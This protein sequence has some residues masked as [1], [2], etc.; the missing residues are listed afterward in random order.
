[1]ADRVRPG[2]RAD[3]F[4]GIDERTIANRA[5]AYIYKLA[6]LIVAP[7]EEIPKAQTNAGRSIGMLAGDHGGAFFDGSDTVDGFPGAAFT[8]MVTAK[9]SATFTGMLFVSDGSSNP[10]VRLTATANCIFNNCRFARRQTDT[11]ASW[12][13]MDAGAK[14]VFNGCR[15]TGAPAAGDVVDNAGVAA[16]AGIIGCSNQTGRVHVNVTNIF[17]VT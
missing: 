8:A 15:F 11:A 10:L 14:A 17:E 9:S 16:N 6:E 3:N 5:V 2:M 1:M 7:G 4:G 13:Q 12:I